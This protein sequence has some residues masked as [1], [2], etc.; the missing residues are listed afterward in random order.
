M[1][2]H[3][4]S[5]AMGGFLFPV[6]L[7]LSM[8]LLSR[9]YRYYSVN[10]F[11]STC[12]HYLFYHSFSLFHTVYHSLC[13]LFSLCVSLSV[14]LYLCLSLFFSL[15]LS[16]SLTSKLGWSPNISICFS[17]FR[18]YRKRSSMTIHSGSHCFTWCRCSWFSELVCTWLGF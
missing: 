16:L 6:S 18:T 9:Y 12:S 7:S 10:I 2:L 11:F 13:L 17:Y 15:C 3:Q 1:I 4:C 5:P 8:C 14:C